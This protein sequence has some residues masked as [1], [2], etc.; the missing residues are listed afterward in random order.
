[1]L[2]GFQGSIIAAVASD[3]IA[4]FINTYGPSSGSGP[5]FGSVAFGVATTD[6]NILINVAW[7]WS[8]LGIGPTRTLSS[9]TIGGVAATIHAQRAHIWPDGG[10]GGGHASGGGGAGDYIGVG[11]A[12]ISA[13]VPSGATGTVALSFTG[14]VTT[15]IGV[16]RSPNIL[17]GV[18]TAGATID[19]G[20]SGSSSIV[21][22]SN[23]KLLLNG[24][25]AANS[26]A[27]TL[28]VSPGIENYN[29]NYGGRADGAI[30]NGLSGGSTAISINI[31]TTGGDAELIALAWN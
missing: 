4:D 24:S 12:I 27:G 14:T 7:V 18:V 28:S 23:G 19:N 29:T 22:P 25:A 3:G 11:G 15:K 2:P 6:R 21:V 10:G 30:S 17:S 20:T 31:S 9:G 8:Q 13:P 5:S 16:Y 1:M 26:A